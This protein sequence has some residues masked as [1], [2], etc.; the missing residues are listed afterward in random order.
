MTTNT[1]RTSSNAVSVLSATYG[2]GPGDSPGHVSRSDSGSNLAARRVVRGRALGQR[3]GS[4]GRGT[5]ERPV[6]VCVCVGRKDQCCVVAAELC[7]TGAGVLNTH[8]NSPTVQ[9][10]N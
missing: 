8:N 5:E 7:V 10:P 3:S 4:G 2:A 6:L 9:P 1:Y